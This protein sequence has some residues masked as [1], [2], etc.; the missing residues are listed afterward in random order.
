MAKRGK[1]IAKYSAAK[2][3]TGALFVWFTLRSKATSGKVL[4]LSSYNKHAKHKMC[5]KRAK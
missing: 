5:Q 1:L 2:T 3:L 4:V